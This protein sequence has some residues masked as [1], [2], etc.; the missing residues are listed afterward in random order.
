MRK[1]IDNCRLIHFM[2]PAVP[3]A[4]FADFDD[5]IW[6]HTDFWWHIFSIFYQ[7]SKIINCLPNFLANFGPPTPKKLRPLSIHAQLGKFSDP[8]C[9]KIPEPYPKPPIRKFLTP[10]PSRIRRKFSCK[11]WRKFRVNFDVKL[12]HLTSNDVIKSFYDVVMLFG[13]ICRF[14]IDWLLNENIRAKIKK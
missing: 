14:I 10:Y 1:W 8:W 3:M 13:F 2:T 5:A 12:R 11:F 6:R 9:R 4:S 7:M